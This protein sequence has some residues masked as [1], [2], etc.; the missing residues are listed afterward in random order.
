MSVKKAS[1]LL[2]LLPVMLMLSGCHTLFNS[3]KG[4]YEGAKEGAKKDWEGLKKAD[5]WLKENLW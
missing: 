5:N 2:L 4:A 3:S 1:L